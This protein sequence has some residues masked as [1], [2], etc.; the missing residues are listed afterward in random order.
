MLFF[1]AKSTTAFLT[2]SPCQSCPHKRP[3]YFIFENHAFKSLV[4]FP[5]ECPASIKQ[6][7]TDP[8]LKYSGA[9]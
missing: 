5:Y 4:T 1:S 7:C 9:S 8:S 3:L 6:K 2:P